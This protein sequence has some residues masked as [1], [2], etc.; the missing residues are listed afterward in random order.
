MFYRLDFSFSKLQKSAVYPPRRKTNK[1]QC[2]QASFCRLC[3]APRQKEK[4]RQDVWVPSKMTKLFFGF[5]I[6]PNVS[7]KFF[8]LISPIFFMIF[9][10][11][12]SF[13]LFIKNVTGESHVKKVEQNAEKFGT[14]TAPLKVTQKSAA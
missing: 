8:S 2:I 3:K 1:L 6:L 10:V 13:M 14:L 9:S 4:N 12:F 7:S 5:S 11:F